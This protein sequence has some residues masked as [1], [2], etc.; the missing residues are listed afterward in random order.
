MTA[1]DHCCAQP[2]FLPVPTLSW[3]DDAD[4]YVAARQRAFRALPLDMHLPTYYRHSAIARGNGLTSRVPYRVLMTTL[5]LRQE[6]PVSDDRND[7]VAKL[8]FAHNARYADMRRPNARLF[9][10][11][12]DG[13]LILLASF[14]GDDKPEDHLDRISQL[15]DRVHNVIHALRVEARTAPAS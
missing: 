11:L 10:E 3:L 2:D 9:T 1:A 15:T 5:E 7:L 4:A 13:T 14:S 12:A 6:L 8:Y